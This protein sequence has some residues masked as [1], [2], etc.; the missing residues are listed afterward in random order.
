M[1]EKKKLKNEIVVQRSVENIFI[2]A[3]V[4][5]QH[6]SL[7]LLLFSFCCLCSFFLLKLMV[8]CNCSTSLSIHFVS[9]MFAK[10]SFFF[11]F[12]FLTG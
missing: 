8:L 11:I 3:L 4:Q 7:P 10:D 9:A 5:E 2:S 1:V 12:V 6:H